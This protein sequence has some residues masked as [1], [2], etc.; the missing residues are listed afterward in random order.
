MKSHSDPAISIRPAT[1]ADLPAIMALWRELKRSHSSLDPGL[2]FVAE[3]EALASSHLEAGFEDPNSVFLVAES[4]ASVVAYSRACREAFPP[5][6][7]KRMHCHIGTLVVSEMYRRAGLGTA[8]YEAT[9][10]A[11]AE[12]GVRYFAVSFMPNNRAAAS[13]WS[14]FGF[15]PQWSSLT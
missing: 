8:L 7:E 11:M 6:F 3:A 14:R 1:T 2:P 5:V 13:F 10:A 15:S 12:R 9:V 4:K